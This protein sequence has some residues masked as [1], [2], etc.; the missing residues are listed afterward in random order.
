MKYRTFK[1]GI[2]NHCYQRSAD[3]GLLFYSQSDYLVWFTTVCTVAPRH[4]IKILG[5]CPMPDHIHMAV[6]AQSRQDLSRFMGQVNRTFSRLQNDVC[7]LKW[8]WFEKPFGSVPKEGSKRGRNCLLY[9]GNN[10]PERQLVQK[11]ED[12]RWTFLAYAVSKHPFSEKLVIRNASWPLRQAIKVIRAQKK[13]EKPL[14]YNLLQRI[15]HKLDPREREQLIDY[16]ISTYDVIDHKEALR[17]F[18][19]SYEKMT[20]ALTLSTAKEY[21]L[22]ET[23]VGWSDKPYATMTHKIMEKYKLDDIHEMLSW[24]QEQKAQAFCFLRTSTQYVPEQI[25]RFL[26]WWEKK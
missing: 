21:D 8:A 1:S 15:S 7:H 20:A 6:I 18:D 11:A 10:P 3:H 2:L 24:P 13:A 19:G 16:I 9:V 26:H 17:L 12:Y 4:N 23:F 22:N 14:K 5:L 25:S